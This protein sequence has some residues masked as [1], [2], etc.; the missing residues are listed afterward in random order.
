MNCQRDGVRTASGSGLLPACHRPVPC[1]S[2]T[3]RAADRGSAVKSVN[4]PQRWMDCHDCAPRP[5]SPLPMATLV[6]TGQSQLLE[7]WT[8]CSSPAGTRKPT[9]GAPAPLD[10]DLLWADFQSKNMG[11]S[12]QRRHHD[13]VSTILL[14]Y[15][16]GRPALS[17]L[18]TT[19]QQR[20]AGRL[21]SAPK[22]HRP[23]GCR[24]ASSIGTSTMGGD[25]GQQRVWLTLRC[26][27]TE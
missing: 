18:F 23:A 13:A 12:R 22:A 16:Y 26:R 24:E 14:P 4:K 10:D 11:D 6:P 5:C 3:T 19:L 7:S 2:A 9:R 20:L 21:S 27:S 15:R 17:R 8:V 25:V 1:S